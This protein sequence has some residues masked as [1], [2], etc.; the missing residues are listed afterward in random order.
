MK[1]VKNAL[2]VSLLVSFIV[3][4][5][6]T[7]FAQKDKAREIEKVL[8]TLHKQGKFNGTALI[9]EKDKVLYKGSR[10]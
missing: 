2:F 4:G 8:G 6:S 3:S 9:V 5:L 1:K 10:I 7:A